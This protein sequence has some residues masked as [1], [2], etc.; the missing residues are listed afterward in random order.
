MSNSHSGL[1]P[2]ELHDR[3]D[4]ADGRLLSSTKAHN[5]GVNVISSNEI[6]GSVVSGSQDKRVKMW[7]NDGM[8]ITRKETKVREEEGGMNMP[9]FV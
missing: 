9:R 6:L 8:Y 7:A 2:F 3:Y 4:G 1:F 5:A